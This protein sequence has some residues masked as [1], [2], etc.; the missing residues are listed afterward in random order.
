[1]KEFVK[2]FYHAHWEDVSNLKKKKKMMMMEEER[3]V[4]KHHSL[5]LFLESCHHH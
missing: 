3:V 1:M 2:E 5:H 4:E